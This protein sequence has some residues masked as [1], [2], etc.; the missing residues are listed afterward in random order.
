MSESF[1]KNENLF[2]RIWLLKFRPI[3]DL[4]ALRFSHKTFPLQNCREVRTPD[5]HQ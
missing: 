1:L 4:S 5:I 3:F 2:L